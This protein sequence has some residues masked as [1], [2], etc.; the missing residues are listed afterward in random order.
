MKEH[1]LIDARSRAFGHAIARK[2]AA[3]PS[4]IQLALGN[5]D[6]WLADCA[7][8]SRSTLEEWRQ[9]L[10]GPMQLVVGLLT[11]D[12]ERSTRLRQSN[13]FAGALTTAERNEI[14]LRFH[15]YDQASA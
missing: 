2:L 12:D 7:P 1:R 6:R 8:A 14:L 15:A 3:D 4:L 13:A 9:A 5:L 11:S 10:E